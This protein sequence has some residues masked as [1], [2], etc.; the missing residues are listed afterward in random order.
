MSLRHAR[1]IEGDDPWRIILETRQVKVSTF[2]EERTEVEI[3][4][5]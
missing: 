5:P 2:K 3:I 1:L 4:I